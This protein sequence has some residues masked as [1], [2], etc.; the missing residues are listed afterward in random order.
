[1]YSCS[2]VFWRT[3]DG[4]LT[5]SAVR[6]APGGDDYQKSWV[7]PAN[8]NIILLVSDQGA[9]VSANRGESWSNWYNQ[10]TAAMYHVTADNAFPYRL[11]SG[12]QDSGSACVDSRGMDG[13]ITFHDWHPVGIEEYGEAAPDPKNPNLVYGGKVTVYN[14]LT[15]QKQNVGPPGGGRGGEPAPTGAPPA[16]T[17]RTQPLIWSPKD[18]NVLFYATA[19]VWKTSN[20]GHSWT[21]ISGDLTR[22]D[23]WEFPSNAGKYASTTPAASWFD[24]G[25]GAIA[26]RCECV[27]G[28]HW[29]WAGSVDHR[30]RSEVDERRAAIEGVDAHLQHGSRAFRYEDGVHRGEHS[31]ARRHESA[32][33]AH[34][35]RRQDVDRNQH[36]NH[37]GKP[38]RR[39]VEFDSRRSSQEGFAVCGDRHAG[40]GFVRRWRSLAFAAPRYAGHFGA[41]YR[42]EG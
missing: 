38:G 42:G 41:R 40:V 15:A 26:T 11:C 29:R 21:A 2:T 24:H 8:S 36:G 16:R 35:R 18:P 4:G 20:G 7:N 33:L 27:V 17:V 31:A 14:R 39:A 30:W 3:E 23:K 28:G 6:G 19:G 13:E 12:Q 9:V 37:I 1:M 10:P 25:A 5:W 34:A 32:F 22:G